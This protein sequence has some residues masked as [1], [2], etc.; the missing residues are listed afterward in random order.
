MY[1]EKSETPPVDFFVL[2][3]VKPKF[4]TLVHA[5]Q[6]ANAAYHN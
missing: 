3:P 6:V 2:D 5:K 4:L 1:V